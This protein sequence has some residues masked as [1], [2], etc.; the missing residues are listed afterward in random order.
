MRRPQ[1]RPEFADPNELEFSL[2]EKSSVV[3]A[4]A[5]SVDGLI[6]GT[7]EKM[8]NVLGQETGDAVH[9]R[10]VADFLDSH[11]WQRWL[12]LWRAGGGFITTR[13]GC[14][15]Q[16][17][18]GLQGDIRRVDGSRGSLI[19]GLFTELGNEQQL[20]KA[21]QHSARM[22]ALGSLTAGIA[23][24]FNNL[25]TVLVGN[26]YLVAE[27]LRGEPQTFA[28]L[29]TA[30][31][32]GK[33][34][35]DLIRQ[36]LAFARR[37]QLETDIV[38]AGKV[39]ADLQPLLRRA[40]GSRIALETELEPSASPIRAS[41]AQ[42]ESVVVNLAINARDA[43]AGKGR[44]AIRV[45]E[46]EI[47]ETEAASRR[48]GRGGPFVA[49][50]VADTGA[51]IAPDVRERVFEPF[52]STK[53]EQGGTGLGLCMV[54]WFAEQAGGAVE[55]E[56]ELN[57]GTTITLFLPKAAGSV[58]DGNDGTMPLSILPTGTEKVLVLATEESLRTTIRQIL[59]VLGY[60]VEFAS[61]TQ[62]LH[63]ELTAGEFRVL[64]VDEAAADEDLLTGLA[65]DRR[66]VG[67]IVA[68]SG[69]DAQKKVSSAGATALAKPFSIAD[70][71]GTVRRVVDGPVKT[72]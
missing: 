21:V 26:L 55:L 12:D 30:R 57:E 27:E 10:N 47:A 18:V 64:I 37:E 67:V 8:R 54:R 44:V 69:R 48:L 34:G 24:D 53:G 42:L 49:I 25:L 1:T 19:Y 39:V 33:R 36:L 40:L 2:L 66:Q 38:D 20:R 11:E 22:E 46:V 63:E 60:T 3:A 50:S 23:H 70:L 14:R 32:A 41:V 16:P 72:E 35:A 15:G 28:K 29:K 52:F 59:Q 6:V 4:I 13:I 68:V 51:G 9:G 43:V 31:D 65:R 61:G 45:R 71:A 7:N 62:R 56:S 17:P 58:T 5:A